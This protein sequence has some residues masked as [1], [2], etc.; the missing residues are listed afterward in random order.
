MATGLVETRSGKLAK[1]HTRVGD[2]ASSE[3]E[4]ERER[5]RETE[6]ETET[7]R[8]NF[9]LRRVVEKTRGLFYIQPSPTRE[10]GT[11]N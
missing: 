11:I 2:H 1:N 8:V 3:R 9:I 6:T 5:E 7:E 4:R 10:T